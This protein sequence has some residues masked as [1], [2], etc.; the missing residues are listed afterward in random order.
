ME[1]NVFVTVR[2]LQALS[3][4]SGESAQD[5][6]IE[7]AVNGFCRKAAGRWHIKYEEDLDETSHVRTHVILTPDCVEIRR[8]GDA[9]VEMLFECGRTNTAYYRLPFGTLVLS[10]F[11]RSIILEEEKDR[12]H[13]ELLYEL[14]VDHQHAADCMTTITVESASAAAM[15]EDDE[16]DPGSMLRQFLAMSEGE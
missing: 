8:S 12:L 11:T 2:G 4:P 9:S 1:R 10:I 13:V 6:P 16:S 15:E 7:T 14:L 5:A 3:L